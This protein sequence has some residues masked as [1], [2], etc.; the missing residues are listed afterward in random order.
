MKFRAEL[1]LDGKTA[2]GITVPPEVLDGLDGGKRPAVRVT[3]NGHTYPSTIGT[4]N[5]V[6]KI[7]V[8]G[9]VRAAANINA[10]DVFDVEVEADHTL[11]T[12]TVPDDLAAALV[13]DPESRAFLDSL[14]YSRKHAYVSWIE[15][16]KKPETRHARV[17][18]TTELLAK[19]RPQR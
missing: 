5:G 7:P 11:R 1:Q 2:T 4:M 9:A 17:T 3:I 18:Q 19:R 10:G 6:A 8:S 13:G 16:A 15:Q 14:S 12:V